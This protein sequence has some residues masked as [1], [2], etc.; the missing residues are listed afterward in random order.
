MRGAFQNQD[1]KTWGKERELL[2]IRGTD[3]WGNPGITTT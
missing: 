3:L 2:S 1:D